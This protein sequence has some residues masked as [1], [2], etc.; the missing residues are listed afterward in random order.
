MHSRMPHS[1]PLELST[2]RAA[3]GIAS[4]PLPLPMLLCSDGE[5]VRE[6]C[7]GDP[8]DSNWI[9]TPQ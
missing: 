3:V 2:F 5:L 4:Q 1:P 7:E 6:N 9:P 8:R